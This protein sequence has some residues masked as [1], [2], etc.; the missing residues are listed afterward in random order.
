VHEMRYYY[1]DCD[2]VYPSI[3]ARLEGVFDSF[4]KRDKVHVDYIDDTHVGYKSYNTR[5][6]QNG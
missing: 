4:A 6:V 5:T 3:S 1:S 2:C